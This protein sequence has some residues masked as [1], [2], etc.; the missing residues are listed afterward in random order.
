[1]NKKK[2]KRDESLIEIQHL[3]ETIIKQR[4]IPELLGSIT[5]FIEKQMSFRMDDILDEMDLDDLDVDEMT[6]TSPF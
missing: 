6:S 3:M 5:K 2:N 4:G 1:M